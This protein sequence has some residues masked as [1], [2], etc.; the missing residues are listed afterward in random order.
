MIRPWAAGGF[1]HRRRTK[2]YRIGNYDIALPLDHVLP[3]VQ[4]DYPLYDR[5]LPVLCRYL[6]SDGW[7]IDVG[8]NVGDT[9]VA[10]AQVCNNPILAIEG[11]ETFAKFL[12]QNVTLLAEGRVRTVIALVGTDAV[13][14][15]LLRTHSTASRDP[16]RNGPSSTPLDDILRTS[17]IGRNVVTLLKV[18]TDGYD[19]DVIVSG[20]DTIKAS[21]PILFWEN[22]ALT[23]EHTSSLNQ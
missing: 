6:D 3:S 22:E 23:P 11:D 4:S 8:A 15:G 17:D 14:G 7:I 19:G 9:A 20:L 5:F 10:I 21:E 12:N 16:H 18:D 13:R 1:F 2:Q